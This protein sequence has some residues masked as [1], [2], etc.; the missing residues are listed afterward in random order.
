ML[1]RSLIVLLVV[2]NLGVG[3]WWLLHDTPPEA[4][5]LQPAGVPRLQLREEAAPPATAPL[6]GA[7]ARVATAAA[8]DQAGQAIACTGEEA[9]AA[10]WRVYLPPLDSLD[11]AEATASRIRAAGFSDLLVMREGVE[12]NSVALGR[13]GT[14]EAAQR[15][16]AALQAAGFMPR[17][18][19]IQR[20]ES[21][22]D[23]PA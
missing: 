19:R 5:L 2:L 6:D 3:A 13:Y 7:V 14:R 23:S 17:C 22:D 11:A 12:A 10:G 8:D 20:D 16:I 18:A 9:G 4:P 21:S 15:R 1:I